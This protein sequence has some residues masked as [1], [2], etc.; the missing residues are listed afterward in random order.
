[1][2][3]SGMRV[4]IMKERLYMSRENDWTLVSSWIGGMI[5]ELEEKGHTEE[6]IVEELSKYVSVKFIDK[7]D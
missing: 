3:K 7:E 4:C 1:M 2:A 5:K 6:Q